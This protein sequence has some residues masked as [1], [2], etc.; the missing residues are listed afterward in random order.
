MNIQSSCR[1]LRGTSLVSLSLWTT[2][3]V[4]YVF[5]IGI[6]T[7]IKKLDSKRNSLNKNEIC[8][9]HCLCN[10]N[11]FYHPAIVCVLYFHVW[12]SLSTQGYYERK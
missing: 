8:K 5:I 4:T 11:Y 10:K 3:G 6:K 2:S 9:S 1:Q 12:F 7:I